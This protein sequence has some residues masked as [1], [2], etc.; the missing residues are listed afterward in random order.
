MT[1]NHGLVTT[2]DDT[3]LTTE[4]ACPIPHGQNV[5]R[6]TSGPGNTG[7]WP[8]RL[9]LKILAKNPAVANPFGTHFDYAEAFESLEP[10]GRGI[11]GGNF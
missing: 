6:P 10:P 2:D 7:W 1:E 4:N 5:S 8:D 11:D 9:N 3:T